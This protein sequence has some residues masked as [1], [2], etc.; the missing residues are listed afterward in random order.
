[1]CAQFNTEMGE[2]DNVVV[3]ERESFEVLMT[4][5]KDQFILEKV[6]QLNLTDYE[7]KQVYIVKISINGN[8]MLVIS[9]TLSF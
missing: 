6:V 9:D 2:V 3:L 7:D 1:M 8:K 4:D 5:L